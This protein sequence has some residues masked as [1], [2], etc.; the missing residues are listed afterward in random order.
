VKI[1][2]KAKVILFGMPEAICEA[3]DSNRKDIPEYSGDLEN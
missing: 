2:G 3:L 1:T